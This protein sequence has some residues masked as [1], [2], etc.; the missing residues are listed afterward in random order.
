M[1]II[2][3]VLEASHQ[4]LQPNLESLELFHGTMGVSAGF[5]PRK[6]HTIQKRQFPIVLWGLWPFD[7]EEPFRESLHESGGRVDTHLRNNI[8]KAA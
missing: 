5:V 7:P 6:R 4:Y 2:T 3:E 8:K 1:N